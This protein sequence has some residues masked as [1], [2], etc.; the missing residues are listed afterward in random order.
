[1]KCRAR[2]NRW[3]EEIQLVEE[4]MRRALEFCRWLSWMWMQRGSNRTGITSH[5]EEGIMAYAAEMAD[6][7]ERRRI[8]WEVNWAS[9]RE[10]A[11]MVL[12]RILNGDKNIEEGIQIPK[13]TVEIE[14]EEGHDY[15]DDISDTD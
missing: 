6:M 13:L 1:M 14:V 4:E 11:K 9:I 8:S 7:E 10:R 15:L 12:E 3:K 5:L 2:A